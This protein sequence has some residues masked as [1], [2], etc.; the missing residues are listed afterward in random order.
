M[1]GNNL[2]NLHEH[3][4]GKTRMSV[5][6]ALCII[7]DAADRLKES[8]PTVELSE[9]SSRGERFADVRN[10]KREGAG[11]KGCRAQPWPEAMANI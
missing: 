6:I 7:N 3:S 10:S 1:K 4:E 5:V 2:L 9:K 11:A 8:S